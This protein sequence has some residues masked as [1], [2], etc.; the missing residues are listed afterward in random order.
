M[1][2]I[3]TDDGSDVNL[4]RFCD[5]NAWWYERYAKQASDYK[6]CQ[7]DAQRNKCGLWADEDPVAPRDWRRIQLPR[8]LPL[9]YS[10]KLFANSIKSDCTSTEDM[11]NL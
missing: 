1:G 6:Q 8:G 9:D 5:G 2:A 4:E 7:E 10:P 11:W 3:Y